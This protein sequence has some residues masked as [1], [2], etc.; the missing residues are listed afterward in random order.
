[1]LKHHFRPSSPWV[2]GVKTALAEAG[3]TQGGGRCIPGAVSS[4]QRRG[5]VIEVC[6]GQTLRVVY[7]SGAAYEHKVPKLLDA[8]RIIDTAVIEGDCS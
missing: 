8:L 6:F 5:V 2:T 3:F 7:T 1:M 4:W